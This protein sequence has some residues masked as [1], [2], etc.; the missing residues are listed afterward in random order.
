MN[1]T[2]KGHVEYT[3]NEYTDSVYYQSVIAHLKNAKI[4]SSVDVGACVGE[5]TK[6]LMES[7]PT[8]TRCL[9]IEPIK[10]NIAFL[11]KRFTDKRIT[12]LPFAMYY[13]ASEIKIGKIDN[14]G[15]ASVFIIE[16]PDKT[17]KCKTITLEAI[18]TPID[19]VKIDVEGSEMNIIEN[20]TQLKEIKFIEIEFHH[21]DMGLDKI[22]YVKKWLPNHKILLEKVNSLFL[23]L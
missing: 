17:E 14:V 2:H 16:T 21:Y 11:L 13:G 10:D 22:G 4:T 12:V 7:I 15:G 5:V 6:M 23:S 20:S 1:S 3:R 8:L 9:M 18:K 19:F